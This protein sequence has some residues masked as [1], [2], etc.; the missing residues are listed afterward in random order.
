MHQ[1]GSKLFTFLFLIRVKYKGIL[2]NRLSPVP[3]L[4]RSWEKNKV[5]DVEKPFTNYQTFITKFHWRCLVKK[6][7]GEFSVQ[8]YI[9]GST[10]FE[11]MEF[12]KT[13]LSLMRF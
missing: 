4:G 7:F 9:N 8:N 3:E 1:S 2:I 5:A 10:L 13:A 6:V 11:Q 12:S